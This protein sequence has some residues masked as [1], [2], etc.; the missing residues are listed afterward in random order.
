MSPALASFCR[1]V[2][3]R[4]PATTAN[5]LPSFVTIR[6]CC[7]P[8][9]LIFAASSSMLPLFCV[10]R[11]LPSQAVSLLSGMLVMSFVMVVLLRWREKEEERLRALPL[12]CG[13]LGTCLCGR[14]GFRREGRVPFVADQ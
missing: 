10:L 8:M 11:T 14:L 7:R 2:R 12:G 13:L 9:A 1:A 5:F 6:F 3:R 4:R